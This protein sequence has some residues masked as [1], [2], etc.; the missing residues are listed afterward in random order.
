MEMVKITREAK[1]QQLKYEHGTGFVEI[2]SK[3]CMHIIYV[4]CTVTRQ[5][6]PVVFIM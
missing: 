6:A 4:E 3:F 5:Y 2:C 1:D